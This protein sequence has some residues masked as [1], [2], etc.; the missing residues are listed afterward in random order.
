MS[1]LVDRFL[2]S[3]LPMTMLTLL[4]SEK[5][6]KENTVALSTW[7]GFHLCHFKIMSLSFTRVVSKM[8]N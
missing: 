2:D 6:Q 8:C 4:Q 1:G 5:T 3:K 7:Y